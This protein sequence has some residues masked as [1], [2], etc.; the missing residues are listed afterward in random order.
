MARFAESHDP[1]SIV[2]EMGSWWWSQC[3]NTEQCL[4]STEVQGSGLR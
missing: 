2:K 1:G 3:L 4:G